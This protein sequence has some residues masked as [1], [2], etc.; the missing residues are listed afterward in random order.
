MPDN[1][2]YGTLC[3][4]KGRYCAVGFMAHLLGISDEDILA[5]PYT[6]Y[7][8]VALEY[9]LPDVGMNSD[10]IVVA[11]DAHRTGNNADRRDRVIAVLSVIGDKLMAKHR[12][13]LALG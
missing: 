12:D 4:G 6:T 2:I 8:R 13:K 7:E 11:N 5:S 10:A 9:G 1:L 3:D